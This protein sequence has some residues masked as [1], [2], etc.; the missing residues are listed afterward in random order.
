MEERLKIVVESDGTFTIKRQLHD[1]GKAGN[2]AAKQVRESWKAAYDQL[3][4]QTRVAMNST[5]LAEKAR[6]DAARAASQEIS[7]LRRSEAKAAQDAARQAAAAA[8]Q[9]TRLEVEQARAR[10]RAEFAHRRKVADAKKDATFGLGTSFGAVVGFLGLAGAIRGFVEYSDAATNVANRLKMVTNSQAELESLTQRLRSTALDARSE[11]DLTTRTYARLAQATKQLNLTQGANLAMTETLTKAIAVSGATGAEAHATLIQLSQAMASNRLSA[12]EFRSVSEQLPI[13]LDLLA[14][15][16]GRARTELKDMGE[17]GKL[18]SRVMALALLEGLDDVRAQF[19]KTTP[20]IEQAWE[21]IRTQTRFAIEEFNKAT[22]AS[23]KVVKALQWMANN[24][25]TVTAAAKALGAMIGVYLIT[26]IGQAAA[27]MVTLAATNPWIA[28]ATGLAAL[29]ALMIQYKDEIKE[30]TTEL[31]YF[32]GAQVVPPGMMTE[33]MKE[34]I[35]TGKSPMRQARERAEYDKKEMEAAKH[36]VDTEM[37]ELDRRFAIADLRNKKDDPKEKKKRKGRHVPTFAEAVADLENDVRSASLDSQMQR[38]AFGQG[39]RIASQIQRNLTEGEMEYV[40]TLVKEKTLL[41]QLDKAEQDAAEAR[42]KRYD[43]ETKAIVEMKRAQEEARE[44]AMRLY[45]EQLG[46]ENR[47]LR[48]QFGSFGSEEDIRNARRTVRDMV[49]GGRLRSDQGAS[50]ME[51]LEIQDPNTKDP[52]KRWLEEM[53]GIGKL[54]D[55]V[56]GIFGP[57]GSLNQGLADAA[58]NAIVFKQSFSGALNA[59][60]KQIQAEII[61]SLIQAG[62]RMAILGGMGGATAAPGVGLGVPAATGGYI[63]ARGKGYAMGG[64]TGDGGRTRIAGYVHGGEGVIKAN[65]MQTIGR[66]AL[67]YMNKTGQIPGGR[68]AVNLKIINNSG[69]RIEAQQGMTREEVVLIAREESYKQSGRA[70][71]GNIRD[72]NS[73][74]GKALRGNTNVRYAR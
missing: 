32:A 39:I 36:A 2:E 51:M 29:I 48:Q 61:S 26:Q 27:A 43:E 69:V 15:S 47:I 12:D 49:A 25:D 22:G 6:V 11:Y 62:I 37:A 67:D 33:E 46:V 19:A 18:T 31:G 70:V 45:K 68:G 50:A 13:I 65:S 1:I 72:P 10:R 66:P 28:A 21:N 23:D 34:A 64:Y 71:A 41:D 8:R 38:D 35:R 20:T 42:Q 52:R 40:A 4:W 3:R 56:N 24:M 14:K 53:H 58:A 17:D 73:H 55:T 57:D 74:V 60:G 63:H 5:K 30:T 59:L 9:V 54:G 7:R 16:T 44:E